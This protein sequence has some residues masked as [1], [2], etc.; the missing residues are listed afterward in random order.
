MDFVIDFALVDWSRALFALTAMYHW[1][2]V[3]FTLGVTFIIAIMFTIYYKTKSEDWKRITKFWTKLLAINFAIW[4]ATWII[5][6]FEFGTNWSNYSWMVWDIFGAPLA[7][8]WIVAFFL[9]TT[10]L[11]ILLFGWDKVSAK[12]QLIAAWLTAL[13]TNLS[14]LW[15]L[16]AN[17]W[18]QHPVG[19]QLNPD[20]LRQEM[21]DFFAVVTNPVAIVKFI[22]TMMSSFTLAAVVVIWVSAYLILKNKESKLAKKSILVASIFGFLAANMT[23]ISGDIAAKEIAKYQPMKLAAM[24]ALNEGQQWA[25]LKLFSIV[26]GQNDDWTYNTYLNIELPYFLSFLAFNDFKAFV[27]WI[28]DLLYGNPEYN[29]ESVIEK[30]RKWKIALESLKTYRSAEDKNSPEA[31]AALQTF[32]ENEKY[33]G[34]AY[35]DENNLKELVPNSPLLFWSFRYMVGMWFWLIVFMALA[36]L[37]VYKDKLESKKWFLKLSIL[38]I[39]LTYLASELGWVVAEV[40]RQPWIIQDLMPTKVATTAASATQIMF[41]FFIFAIIFTVLL[42]AALKIAF[43]RIRQWF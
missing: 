36:F 38:M 28:K 40:W 23:V 30:I 43:A 24:E 27:P 31:Q 13:G 6:E 7:I 37:Y 26:R 39:P 17:A 10:F 29:V 19:M 20:T 12:T 22:H 33:F 4:V 16:I 14:G 8:E 18:M 32:R 34:Y 1:L 35:F 3:P 11:I 5:L 41:I 25:P 9:E 42:I 15:I 21:V 2:F